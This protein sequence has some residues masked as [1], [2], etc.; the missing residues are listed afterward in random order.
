MAGE[1]RAGTFWFCL[2]HHRVERF[3]DCDSHNRMG[4]YSTFGDAEQAIQTHDERERAWDA[5]DERWN[6]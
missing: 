1:D 6:D 5:E 2:D 4:P 3:E